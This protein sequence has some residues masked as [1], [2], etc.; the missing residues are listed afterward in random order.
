M[1]LLYADCK[2][3]FGRR[4]QKNKRGIFWRESFSVYVHC[5]GRPNGS[6]QVLAARNTA[7]RGL[8]KIILYAEYPRKLQM[9]ISP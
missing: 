9:L 6:E 7:R 1:N 2:M 8:T 5:K 4:A 3:R